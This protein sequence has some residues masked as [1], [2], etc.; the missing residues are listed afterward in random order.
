MIK[1]GKIPLCPSGPPGPPG[2]SGQ[3]GT[4]GPKGSAGERRIAL[5]ECEKIMLR[6]ITFLVIVVDNASHH[7]TTVSFRKMSCHRSK[8][9]IGTLCF[10]TFRFLE[11]SKE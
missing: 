8:L 1:Y 9:R 7:R 2:H 11:R 3:E 10:F 6:M 5:C 4:R